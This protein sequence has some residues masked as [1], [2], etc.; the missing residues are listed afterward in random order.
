M[1]MGMHTLAHKHH[2]TQSDQQAPIKLARYVFVSYN[3]HKSVEKNSPLYSM[4]RQYYLVAAGVE[5]LF[6]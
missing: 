3:L 2:E 5:R 1:I 4:L 6:Y